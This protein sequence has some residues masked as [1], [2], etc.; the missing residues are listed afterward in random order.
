MYLVMI[1]MTKSVIHRNKYLYSDTDWDNIYKI[2]WNTHQE[3][4]AAGFCSGEKPVK[5]ED[6]VNG[7]GFLHWIAAIKQDFDSLA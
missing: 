5:F 1:P 3:N 4:V 7:S 2:L 6:A